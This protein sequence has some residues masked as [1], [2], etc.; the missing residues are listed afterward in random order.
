MKLG[1]EDWRLELY[2]SEEA[3]DKVAANFAGPKTIYSMS[4]PELA[5][6]IRTYQEGRIIVLT[7]RQNN[8]L[9]KQVH[10]T[11]SECE[12]KQDALQY[13]GDIR[14]DYETEFGT[15]DDEEEVKALEK[16]IA[17]LIRKG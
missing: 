17:V 4:L 8:F 10:V 14:F 5:E 13:L 11:I 15:L 12:D 2:P 1:T 9:I 6:A 16:Y 3:A 7:E